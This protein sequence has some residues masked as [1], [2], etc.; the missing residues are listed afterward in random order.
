LLQQRAVLLRN[1][2]AAADPPGTVRFADVSAAGGSYFAVPHR[3]RGAAFGDLDNDGRIDAVVSH[4]NEPI[5][6]LRNVYESPSHWLGVALVGKRHRDATGAKL[7][8]EQGPARQVRA[9]TGGGSYCSA[10][11]PRVVFAL[12][13]EGTFQLTVRWPSGTEQKWTGT[14][15]GRNRYVELTEGNDTPKVM[16]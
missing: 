14:A 8:L 11:D 16:K 6:V 10:S 13:P 5:A 12:A 3:G 9:V 1:L 2:R 4:T 7:V 15:L